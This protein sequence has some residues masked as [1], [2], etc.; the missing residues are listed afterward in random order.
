MPWEQIAMLVTACK[1]RI[2]GFTL[3]ELM[4]AVVILSIATIGLLDVYTRYTRINMDNVMRNEAM[5]IAEGRLEQIRNL[6]FNQ[7]TSTVVAATFPTSVTGTVRK[8][9]TTFNVA[10]VINALS[11]R[12]DAYNENS[13]AVLV[14][15]TWNSPGTPPMPHRHSA[16]T[17]VT[18]EW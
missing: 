13:K 15:V 14:T 17:V 8:V 16:A 18:D 11:L 1:N 2:E 4:V 7:L 6:P 12:L 10:T 5:R 3:I 9:T